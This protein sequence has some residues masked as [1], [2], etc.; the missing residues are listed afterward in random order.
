MKLQG[1]GS[2][3]ARRTIELT[4]LARRLV[5]GFPQTSR[6]LSDCVDR[7]ELTDIPA[8]RTHQNSTRGQLASRQQA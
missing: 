8:Y 3:I 4:G 1:L 7:V 5:C 2:F 6:W